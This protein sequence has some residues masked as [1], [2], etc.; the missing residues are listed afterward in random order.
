MLGQIGAAPLAGGGTPPGTPSVIGVSVYG[1][2]DGRQGRNGLAHQVGETRPMASLNPL[3]RLSAYWVRPLSSLMWLLIL[4]LTMA[5]L[6]S[7]PSLMKR[8]GPLLKWSPHPLPLPHWWSEPEAYWPLT[9][10][11]PRVHRP[12]VPQRMPFP[13]PQLRPPFSMLRG[14]CGRSRSGMRPCRLRS[15]KRRLKWTSSGSNSQ[16]LKGGLLL[17]VPRSWTSRGPSVSSETGPFCTNSPRCRRPSSSGP[18]RN[19]LQS[20]MCQ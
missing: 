7:G 17:L 10:P 8:P 2:A 4:S 18:H 13:S 11:A 14:K 9:R 5:P 12:M 15:G 1:G 3:S 16:P 20:A 6:L 19:G